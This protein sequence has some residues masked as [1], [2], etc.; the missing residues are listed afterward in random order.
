MVEN[1]GETDE[2]NVQAFGDGPMKHLQIA[3]STNNQPSRSS[4]ELQLEQVTSKSTVAE[5]ICE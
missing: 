4:V 3:G 2:C 1:S 5:G